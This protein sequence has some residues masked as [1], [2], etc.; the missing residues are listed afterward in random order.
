MRFVWLL[1]TIGGIALAITTRNPALLALGLFVAFVGGLF[2]VF[3]FAAARIEST[4]RP[5]SALLTPEVLAAVR[6]RAAQQRAPAARPVPPPALPTAHPSAHPPAPR[7][8]PPQRP[9]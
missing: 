9:Q 3:T 7:P 6:A 1:L 5:D 2:A 8:A 4:A